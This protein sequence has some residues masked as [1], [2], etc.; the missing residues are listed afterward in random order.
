M[1]VS[2]FRDKKILKPQAA[3]HSHLSAALPPSKG[4]GDFLG[5][6]IKS[7]ASAGHSI[8]LDLEEPRTLDLISEMY[9]LAFE[10]PHFEMLFAHFLQGY[11]GQ[12]EP[13]NSL[14]FTAQGSANQF[15]QILMY[16]TVYP[17][18]TS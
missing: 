18:T 1:T 4:I 10:W 8:P 9:Q 11:V 16:A 14:A 2:P 3:V 6:R 7:N 13:F 15:P 17:R 5:L 12:V